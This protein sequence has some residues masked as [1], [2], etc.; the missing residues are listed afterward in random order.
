MKGMVHH[1]KCPSCQVFAMVVYIWHEYLWTCADHMALC[2]DHMVLCADHA[3]L[4]CLPYKIFMVLDMPSKP[5]A[6]PANAWHLQW[7]SSIKLQV[8]AMTKLVLTY[9]W[10]H[11]A[12]SPVTLISF[13]TSGIKCQV[14]ECCQ[15]IVC[16]STSCDGRAT[17]G[18]SPALVWLRQS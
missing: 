7:A 17:T 18:L 12:S 11:T 3:L 2:I 1:G 4:K 13:L 8:V 5:S 6:R 15:R 14:R 9:W 16:S 10:L